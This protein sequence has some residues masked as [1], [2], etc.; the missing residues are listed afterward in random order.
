MN[1]LKI[2]PLTE[3]VLKGLPERDRL[4]LQALNTVEQQGSHCIQQL[5]ELGLAVKKLERKALLRDRVLIGTCV[6][7][8]LGLAVVVGRLSAGAHL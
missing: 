4:V 3:D 6:T 8:L 7:I 2:T 5:Q 1:E